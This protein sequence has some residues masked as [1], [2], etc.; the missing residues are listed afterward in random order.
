MVDCE[1]ETVVEDDE[2]LPE[3]SLSSCLVFKVSGKLRCKWKILWEQKG[4]NRERKRREG[5]DRKGKGRKRKER[6]EER[7]K[8]EIETKAMDRTLNGRKERSLEGR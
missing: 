8:S 3:N 1:R 7:E 5:Q 6:K 2:E 4:R